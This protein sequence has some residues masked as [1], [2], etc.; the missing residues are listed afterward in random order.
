MLELMRA[1]SSTKLEKS[2]PKRKFKHSAK[3]LK[4]K[5]SLKGQ[6]RIENTLESSLVL[7]D[8]VNEGTPK[9]NLHHLLFTKHEEDNSIMKRNLKKPT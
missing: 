4:R 7:E 6:V 9:R 5:S 2:T 8:S 3:R 1:P